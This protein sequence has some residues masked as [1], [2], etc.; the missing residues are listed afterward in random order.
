MGLLLLLEG[1]QIEEHDHEHEQHHDGP[2]VHQDLDHSHEVGLGEEEDGGHVE[3]R[4]HQ[5][6]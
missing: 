5:Q 6:E 4:E 1:A 3:E 2:C